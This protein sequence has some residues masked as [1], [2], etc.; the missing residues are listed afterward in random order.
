M[1]N[2]LK[3]LDQGISLAVIKRFSLVCVA[4]VTTGCAG[5]D[6]IQRNVGQTAERQLQ[7]LYLSVELAVVEDSER[8]ADRLLKELDR[9]DLR[10]T[11]SE[12]GSEHYVQ[13]E[14]DAALLKIEEIDRRIEAGE[15]RRTYARTSLTQNRGRKKHEK[16][17][18]TLRASLIDVTSGQMLFQSDYVT[19][20]PWYADSAS[21]VASL[22]APL[23]RQLEKDG[24]ISMKNGV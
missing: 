1:I 19:D 21:V 5:A 3:C 10:L 24:F 12:Q 2:S 13:T 4:L 23:A 20:G 9:Y 17:V 15:H 22:A 14:S 16:P 11:L 6:L 8:L 18:I 7:N